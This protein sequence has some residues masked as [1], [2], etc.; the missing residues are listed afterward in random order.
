MRRIFVIIFLMVGLAGCAGEPVWA[1][2]DAVQRAN[3]VHPGPS[4]LTLFTVM[5]LDTGS[6]GHSA[7]MV[8]APSGRV[9]F[10]PAGSFHHPRLPERN[11]VVYGM[12]P[13][14]VVFYNDYHSRV[15]WET[16]MQ[17]IPVSAAVA[18]SAKRA[19]EANGATPKAFCANHISTILSSLPGFEDIGVTMFPEDI[20]EVWSK[21]PGVT[22]QRFHDN[23]PNE[24]GEILAR[25]I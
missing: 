14:A 17:E 9:L 16:Y 20:M 10:D 4:S 23:D 8:N 5:N 11:D 7:L 15:S 2:D 18:E 13:A 1:P 24:N 22:T 12:T 19:V 6:G 21:K 3:Y 25:G